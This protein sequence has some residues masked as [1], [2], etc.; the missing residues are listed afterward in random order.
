MLETIGY[1]KGDDSRHIGYGT[2]LLSRL[3]SV[4]NELWE[5]VNRRIQMLLPYAMGVVTDLFQHMET[6][7]TERQVDN[8]W[9]LD[10]QSYSNF[11]MKQFQ[12]R[13]NVLERAKSKSVDEIYHESE[14][15]IGIV[16]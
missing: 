10:Q 7:L 2:Y 16:D 6:N 15:A 3:I 13:M 11:A 9:Q 14:A 1:L 5:V 12:Y 8:P 4:N